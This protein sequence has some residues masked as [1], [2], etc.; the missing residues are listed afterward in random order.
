[1]TFDLAETQLRAIREGKILGTIDCQQYL[2]GFL[3][4]AF[5][6][7]HIRYGFRLASDILTG[8][9]VVDSSNLTVAAEGVRLGVR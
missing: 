6:W 4:M 5:L 1:M 2:Q 3:G 8:P 7:L 9:A